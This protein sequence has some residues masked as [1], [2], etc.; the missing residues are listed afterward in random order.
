MS[1]IPDNENTV[2]ARGIIPCRSCVIPVGYEE[3]S[4]VSGHLIVCEMGFEDKVTVDRE[5]R[6]FA[7]RPSPYVRVRS[8]VDGV[9]G[10]PATSQSRASVGRILHETL[11]WADRRIKPDTGIIVMIRNG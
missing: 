3:A 11:T 2:P 10:S 7:R 6:L 9:E 4:S 1:I 8:A 5:W